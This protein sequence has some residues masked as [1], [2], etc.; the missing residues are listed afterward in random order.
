[1][2]VFFSGCSSS[3]KVEEPEE[4]SYTT[5]VTTTA[6]TEVLQ[7]EIERLKNENY[8]YEQLFNIEVANT[9]DE[10]AQLYLS[11]IGSPKDNIPKLKDYLTEDYYN[12]LLSTIGH[13]KIDLEFEQSTGILNLFVSDYE[14]DSSFNVIALCSQTTLYNNEVSNSNTAYVFKLA[15]IDDVCKICSVEKIF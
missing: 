7:K 13:S 2:A 12:H 4:T 8:R 3:P 9:I 6:N 5:E 15:Y 1:M 14:F 10:Y 11:Y